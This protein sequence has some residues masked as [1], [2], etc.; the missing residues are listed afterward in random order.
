MLEELMKILGELWAFLQWASPTIG[1]IIGPALGVL[2]GFKLNSWGSKHSNERLVREYMKQLTN[3]ILDAIPIL[4]R[5]W[6]QL[7][8]DDIWKSVVNSGHLA[9]LPY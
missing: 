5:K 4:E 1:F 6:L 2:G 9:L 7:L 3:E 8:P